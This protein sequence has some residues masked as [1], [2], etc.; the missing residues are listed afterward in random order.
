M[1]IRQRSRSAK[2]MASVLFVILMLFPGCLQTKSTSH[3][4]WHQKF[5]WQ[6]G[7]YFTT[8][9]EIALCNAIEANDLDEMERLI[10]KGADVNAR[11]VGS[12][13]P[14]LWAFP[15]NKMERFKLL[16]GNGANPNVVV[17]SDF[18]THGAIIPGDSVTHLAART[19]FPEHFL[20]VMKDG[21]NPNLEHRRHRATPLHAVIESLGAN[22]C[23]R[24]QAL[25]NAGA[26]LEHHS[27]GDAP[28]K[29]A[30]ARGQYEIVLQLLHAG[31]DYRA[32]GDGQLTR[33]IH[34]LAMSNR[35]KDDSYY[36]LLRWLEVRGE[37]LEEAKVD[38]ARWDSW[39]GMDPKKATM[40]R[41]KEIAARLATEAQEKVP[42]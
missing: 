15:D 3:S 41:K 1:V 12:M 17:E 38:L 26:D 22:K 20:W 8:P 33:L 5:K 14:L 29:H 36:K 2:K 18:G 31:A 24:I 19:V 9:L 34:V 42:K 35:P 32:Y 30:I 25:I 4:S 27:L 10:A 40:L 28:A 13:T 39:N 11:G 6:A 7:E 23:E 21:G 37:S 16:L